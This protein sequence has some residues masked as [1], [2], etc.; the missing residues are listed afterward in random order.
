[1]RERRAQW[2]LE[3]RMEKLEKFADAAMKD[4]HSGWMNTSGMPEDMV[5]YRYEHDTLQSWAGVFPVAADETVPR[6]GVILLADSSKA[7]PLA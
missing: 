6:E 5:I 1:M 4:T 2:Q 7:S 3:R